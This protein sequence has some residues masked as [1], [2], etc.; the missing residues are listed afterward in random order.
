MCCYTCNQMGQDT[1]SPECPNHSLNKANNT[2]QLSNSQKLDEDQET[3]ADNINFL[4]DVGQG[5]SQAIIRYNQVL[6]CLEKDNQDDKTLFKFR[7]ITGHQGPLDNDAPNYKGCLYRVMVEWKTGEITEEPF[8]IIAADDP[9]TCA[10]YA[11]KHNL[12]KL[13]GWRRFKNIARNQKSFI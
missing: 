8:S 2:E 12:L 9:V 10:A 3:L 6:N 4:L 11:K 13:P 7:A 1:N 5:R